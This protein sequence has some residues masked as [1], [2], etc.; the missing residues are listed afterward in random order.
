MTAIHNPTT[1]EPDPAVTIRA[2]RDELGLS[3]NKFAR[4]CRLDPA[5]IAGV[6]LRGS[7]PDFV[8]LC[9]LVAFAGMKPASLIGFPREIDLEAVGL[10][11]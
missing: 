11:S 3:R 6:E 1:T 5:T 7:K 9:K 8:T 2:R 4:L 10:A